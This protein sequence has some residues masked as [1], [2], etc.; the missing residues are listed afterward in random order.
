MAT[1]NHDA[2]KS[3]ESEATDAST[4]SIASTSTSLRL[5]PTPELRPL[6]EELLELIGQWRDNTDT[7]P[8]FTA[9]ELIVIVLVLNDLESQSRSK[10]YREILST[11][12]YYGVAAWRA[13]ANALSAQE[14][15]GDSDSPH[16]EDAVGGF[17]DSMRDFELPMTSVMQDGGEVYTIDGPAARVYLRKHLEPPRQGVFNFMGLP[18]E[19]RESVLKMLLVFPKPALTLDH[20]FGDLSQVAKLGLLSRED[21]ADPTYGTVSRPSH[22]KILAE[23]LEKTL[24]VLGVSNQMRDEAL[25]IFYGQNAFRFGSLEHLRTAVK[26]MTGETLEQIQDLRIVM[27][28]HSV[29]RRSLKAYR[30]LSPKKLVL[31]LPADSSFWIGCCGGFRPESLATADDFARL[32]V[33][34]ELWDIVA[35]A[36]RAEHFEMQGTGFLGRWLREKVDSTAGAPYFAED[37]GRDD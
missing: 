23:P 4:S 33:L 1:L 11:F 36:K 32:D 28:D 29:T 26:K 19:L 21:K 20:G 16:L 7:E 5:Q 8:P 13:Y 6:K 18:A 15:M 10:I 14:D 12:K 9:G 27:D 37:D 24:A 30:L 25:P 17:H 34:A 3:I 22:T 35:L 31:A 2:S